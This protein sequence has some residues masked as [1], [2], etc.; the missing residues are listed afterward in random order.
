MS[1]RVQGDHPR[2]E[3]VSH[4]L[5]ILDMN[6]KR[7]HMKQTGRAIGITLLLMLFT[8]LP[9]SRAAHEPAGVKNIMGTALA[10]LAT[11]SIATSAVAYEE[12]AITDGGTLTGT[13]TLEGTVPRPKGYNLTTLPDPF[14]CGRISDGQG[15]RILQ[16]FQV[17][18]AG[19]FR[20]VVGL[21]RGHRQRQTLRRKGFA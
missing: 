6:H 12:I 20:D 14:Y 3:S 11:I 19:E 7:R 8:S 1:L 5:A 13:V 9:Y 10:A 21:S 18:P 17:G 15:W 2:G 4:R 16:P